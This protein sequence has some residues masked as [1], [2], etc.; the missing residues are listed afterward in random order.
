MPVISVR[1]LVKTYVVGEVT[2]RAL[3][4]ANMD[5]E[6]GEFEL[7]EGARS[8]LGAGVFRHVFIEFNGPRLAE[9]GRTF[10]DL[11][12]CFAEHGYHPADTAFVT[13]LRRSDV[14]PE[15]RVVNLRFQRDD[16]NSW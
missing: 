2:V 6:A 4:G 13:K 3:R 9:R 12:G 10:D 1:D 8:A 14:P 11:L 15:T 5:V 7:L 16:R